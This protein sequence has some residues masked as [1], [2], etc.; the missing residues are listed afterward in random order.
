MKYLK[1]YFNRFK[2]F[3]PITEFRIINTI[4][5]AMG[6]A[7]LVPVIISLKGI[8]FAA[9][10]IGTFSIIQTL[11]VKSNSYIVE[12]VSIRAMFR[13]GIYIHFAYI[14][15]SLFYFI[16]PEIMLWTDSIL[17]IVEVAL[18]SA[19]SISL[20]NY[21]TDEHPRDMSKF[22][23]IRNSVW[24]DGYL[25]GLFTVTLVTYF[26]TIGQAV[27]LFII[28]N[29]LFNI[30]MIKNWNIYNDNEYCCDSLLNKDIK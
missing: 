19:F 12:K 4:F 15:M 8:Y 7:L 6:M 9:W 11:T 20:N 13:L 24:A 14:G 18:F 1:N 22:Q 21:I 30:W 5:V 29:V 2:I 28:F 23:I 3:D 17:G 27:I 16:S 26:G 10:L 25:I